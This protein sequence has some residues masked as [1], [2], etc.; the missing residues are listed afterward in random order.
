MTDTASLVPAWFAL[1]VVGLPMG[2][3]GLCFLISYSE[4][5]N[6]YHRYRQMIWDRTGWFLLGA[7]G[8]AGGLVAWWMYT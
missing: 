1:L 6:A 4:H 3:A 5:H 7:S 2:L 8:M